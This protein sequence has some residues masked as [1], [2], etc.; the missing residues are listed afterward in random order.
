MTVSLACRRLTYAVARAHAC[1]I[2]S[3]IFSA[4]MLLGGIEACDTVAIAIEVP[5]AL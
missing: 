4:S 3:K 5:A 1:G 2:V